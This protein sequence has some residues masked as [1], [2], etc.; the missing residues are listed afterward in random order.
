MP[1]LFPGEIRRIASFLRNNE[2][3][4]EFWVCTSAVIKSAAD[5]MGYTETIEAAGGML[6]SDTCMVVAPVEELGYGV[7]GVDSAKAAN[8]IPGMC[9]LEAVYDDW[10]NLLSRP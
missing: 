1:P 9:G 8:Y 5:R 2:P 10:M 7:L 3:G 4:V 6:V